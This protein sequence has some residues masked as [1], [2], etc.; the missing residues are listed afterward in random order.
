MRREQRHNP[1][2]SSGLKG[3][4]KDVDLTLDLIVGVVSLFSAL[5]ILITLGPWVMISY[6]IGWEVIGG[7]LEHV[8]KRWI[9]RPLRPVWRAIVKFLQLI[10]P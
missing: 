6:L 9:P 7:T 1:R 8:E 3:L 5:G 4:E 2:H 10:A